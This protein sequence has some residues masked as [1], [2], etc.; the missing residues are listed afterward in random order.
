MGFIDDT[1]DKINKFK[2][3]I[4][5]WVADIFKPETPTTPTPRQVQGSDPI[6]AKPNTPGSNG[7]ISGGGSAGGGGGNTGGSGSGGGTRNAARVKTSTP[8]IE[9]T[10]ILNTMSLESQEEFAQLLL[11]DI[12]G[13]ELSIISRRGAV[14]GINV[15]YQPI[16]DLSFTVLKNNSLNIDPNPNSKTDFFDVVKLDLDEYVPTPK[17]LVAEGYDSV[18]YFNHDDGSLRINL[19][20]ITSQLVEIEFIKIESIYDDT[21]YYGDPIEYSS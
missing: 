18:V 5:P 3:P 6:P 16:K 17:E 1:I 7:S 20:D 9:M 4:Q 8:D 12:G 10:N 19:K 13:R 11:D 21:I 14:D 2:P 15:T